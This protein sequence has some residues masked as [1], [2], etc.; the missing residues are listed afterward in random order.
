MWSEL[1]SQTWNI[2]LYKG[3]NEFEM[4][5]R[6]EIWTFCCLG[7]SLPTAMCSLSLSQLFSLHILANWCEW[8]EAQHLIRVKEILLAIHVSRVSPVLDK[9]GGRCVCGRVIRSLGVGYLGS[10]P[11]GSAR[12]FQQL[13]RTHPT[14]WCFVLRLH[15]L[16]NSFSSQ[17]CLIYCAILSLWGEGNTSP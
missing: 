4:N 9:G 5:I 12:R 17:G 15:L 1:F 16:W 7:S 10:F 14:R 6:R 11:L 2:S 8:C 13:S 3:W